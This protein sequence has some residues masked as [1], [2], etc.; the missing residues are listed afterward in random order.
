MNDM[1]LPE[2][3]FAIES[4]TTGVETYA[5][6]FTE[7]T[8]QILSNADTEPVPVAD[9][10][11]RGYV[12]WGEDNDMPNRMLEKIRKDEVMSSNK[13]FNILTCYGRGFEY[14]NPDNS[15]VTDEAINT[16]FRRN[17]M[18]KFWAERITDMKHFFF[19][20]MVIILDKDG[21]KIVQIR[22]KEAVHC[23]FETCNPK[24]G[25]VENVF[26]S[27]KWNENPG[28]DDIET[29]SLL[30]EDDPIGDLMVRLGHEPDPSTGSKRTKTNER[31][32]AIVIKVPVPGYKYYPFPYYASMFNSGWADYKAMIPVA[33]IAKMKNGLQVRYIIELHEDYWKRLWN[34][35]GITDAEE[36]KAR[37]TVEVKNIKDFLSGY[38]NSNKT[39]ITTYYM[40]PNGKEQSMVKITKVEHTKEG[41]DFIEDSEEVTNIISYADGVHT[42]LIGATPGKSKGS[43]SGSDKRELFTMKQALEKLP[44]DLMLFPFQLLNEINGWDLNYTIGDL[45]LTTLDEGT[46]AKET[47]PK[48]EAD[49]TE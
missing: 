42:S 45:L 7:T 17:N 40:D 2:G 34:S 3:V 11:T 48:I 5:A 49:D 47:T 35:E 23:R 20:V 12:P 4:I 24:T 32:F 16:F 37:K 19:T 10:T 22:H 38:E 18:I 15:V 26:F 46:D 39:W 29:I 6:V 43:F 13:W 30:D 41:G 44:R 33:K 8:R 21:N 36:K 14:L 27:A 31:I 25:I 9:V 1:Q 28:K